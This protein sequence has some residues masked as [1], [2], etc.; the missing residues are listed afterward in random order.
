MESYLGRLVDNPIFIALFIVVLLLVIVMW[1]ALRI[2]KKNYIRRK[3]SLI[4]IDVIENVECLDA[5]DELIYIDNLLI[6]P[7]KLIACTVLHYEGLIFAAQEI[8]QWTQVLPTGSYKFTNPYQN[9]A[10]QIDALQKLFPELD[11]EC[12]LFFPK[13]SFPKDKPTAVMTMDDL[14]KLR[15][16]KPKEIA[17]LPQKIVEQWQAIKQQAGKVSVA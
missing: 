8:E 12:R 10:T 15:Q 13:A 5:V 14:P 11:I 3:L 16:Y 9:F 7:D 1:L 17:Y 2:G 6:Q 4:A